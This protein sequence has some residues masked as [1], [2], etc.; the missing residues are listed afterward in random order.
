M[1]PWL[2]RTKLS[3]QNYVTRAVGHNPFLVH[4]FLC[5]L[6]FLVKISHV[7]PSP[8]ASQMNNREVERIIEK[9]GTHNSGIISCV[10]ALT[11]VYINLSDFYLLFNHN[12]YCLIN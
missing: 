11:E 1:S 12:Y 6:D 9:L 5:F 2:V 4:F 7:R 8:K 10:G 3:N